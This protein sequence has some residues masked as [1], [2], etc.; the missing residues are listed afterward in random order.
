MCIALQHIISL[1]GEATAAATATAT[2][3]VP[4]N[5]N[6]TFISSQSL[7]AYNINFFINATVVTFNNL[8]LHITQIINT[9]TDK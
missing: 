6:F 4:H 5:I 9:H 1:N 2:A 7:V 8:T 3:T